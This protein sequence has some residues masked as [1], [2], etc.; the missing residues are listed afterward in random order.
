[1][2][3]Q[4]FT[5]W[6][7]RLLDMLPWRQARRAAK[8]PPQAQF[9][10]PRNVDRFAMPDL[11]RTRRQPIETNPLCSTLPE[12]APTTQKPSLSAEPPSPGPSVSEFPAAALPVLP[13]APTPT[14]ASGAAPP[15]GT[16]ENAAALQVDP[17]RR[18]AFARF[19]VRRGVFN[20]GFARESLPAQYRRTKSTDS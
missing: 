12:D 19:L 16:E 6:L 10:A 8:R 4:Q 11:D 3:M 13:S 2:N 17:E 9:I 15:S 5:K 7:T 14:S 1:M 18:L 20:E